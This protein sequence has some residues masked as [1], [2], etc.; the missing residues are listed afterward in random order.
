MSINLQ[1]ERLYEQIELVR[2]GG[3]RTTG[4]LCIMSLVAYLAD[5]R[6]NDRPNTASQFIRE[7]A[8]QLNDGSPT[9][10]R[11]ELKPFAP[12]IIGTNDGYDFERAAL[13]YQ[14]I[15]EEVWPRA[16]R[17]A[18]VVREVVGYG[19]GIKGL[20]NFAAGLY[21]SVLRASFAA[22][23]RALRAAHERGDCLLI[24]TLAGQLL[25]A[26][27]QRAPTQP[28]YW[29]K[30]LELLDRLCDVGADQRTSS[31]GRKTEVQRSAW[32]RSRALARVP[33]MKKAARE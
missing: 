17:D 5:E 21:R 3:T 30:S 27:V 32:Q 11:Q 9:D 14:V 15:M 10:L 25:V 29:A 26:L 33:Y 18:V 2:G 1:T 23:F 16:E 24:G 7:F 4:R 12:Q 6:D 8:I 19:T 31:M 20:L 22:R 13:A 28:W